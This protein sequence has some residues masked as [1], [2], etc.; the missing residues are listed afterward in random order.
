MKHCF[1]NSECTENECC[2]H[3]RAVGVCMPRRS[4]GDVCDCGCQKNLMC[5]KTKGTCEYIF[6][7]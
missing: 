7:G 6:K 5:D 3:D 4:Y 2:H 1:D